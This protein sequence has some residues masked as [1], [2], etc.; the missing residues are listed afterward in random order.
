MWLVLIHTLL[1][2]FPWPSPSAES[3]VFCSWSRHVDA[4]V[5]AQANKVSRVSSTHTHSHT[6]KSHHGISPAFITS[7]PREELCCCD[8]IKDFLSGAQMKLSHQSCCRDGMTR[9]NKAESFCWIILCLSSQPRGSGGKPGQLW[10]TSE[11]QHMAGMKGEVK[12]EGWQGGPF[13]STGSQQAGKN[14]DNIGDD[15]QRVA[16]KAKGKCTW[17]DGCLMRPTYASQDV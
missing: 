11:Q 6:P 16:T 10:L 14:G 15:S 17:K 9:I 4:G 13:L 8:L 5:S 3:T 1:E 7:I 12:E 2:D